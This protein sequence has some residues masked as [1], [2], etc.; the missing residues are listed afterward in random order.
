MQYTTRHGNATVSENRFT[1]HRLGL[2][3]SDDVRRGRGKQI[4]PLPIK[5][6]CQQH[7][8]PVYNVPHNTTWSMNNYTVSDAVINNYNIVLVISFGYKIPQSI[9]DQFDLVLNIH[10]SLLPLYRGASPIQHTLLHNDHVTGV[11]IIQLNNQVDTGDIIQQTRCS[12]DDNDTY[13]TLHNKL[14]ELGSEMIINV[15]CNLQQSMNNMQ[16]QSRYIQL[17]GEL[18]NVNKLRAPK[19]PKSSGCIDVY[20]TSATHIC[21]QY[22]SYHGFIPLYMF[23]NNQRLLIVQMSPVVYNQYPL[24]GDIGKLVYNEHDECILIKCVDD[25]CISIQVVH[26]EYGKSSITAKHFMNYK[27]DSKQ[28]YIDKTNV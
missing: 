15:L 19:I 7:N 18:Y 6:Y 16:S 17:L 1:V 12:I 20:N 8:I 26:V 11:S 13:I 3:C 27:F 24:D 22:R 5:S 23:Y 25:N 10:P 21:T 4:T 2:L 14:S 28:P 9:L